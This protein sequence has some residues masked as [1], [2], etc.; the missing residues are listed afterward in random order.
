MTM[1]QQD[2]IKAFMASLA[3]HGYA[4]SNTVGKDMLDSAI[5][6]SSRYSSA[7]DVAAAMAADQLAAER[8]ALGEVLGS[9]YADKTLSEISSSIRSADA[10]TY[11]GINKSNA[12]AFHNGAIPGATVTVEDVV[13]ERKAYI[14]LEDYCGI[15]L[16][17]CYWLTN[18]NV[19]Q[20]A[21]NDGKPI[22]TTGNTDTGAITGSDADGSSTEKTAASVVPETYANTYKA[23]T[24]TAQTIITN[25][26]NW[27]VQAT[28]ND[29]TI[30]A[31]GADSI[32]AAAG[33][34]SITVNAS[35]ATVTSGAGEDVITVSQTVNDITLSDLNSDDTLT[36]S[37][38]FEIGSAHIED[39]LL[40]VT[41]KTGTRKIRLGD[42]DNAQNASV[43]INGSAS[44]TIAQWLSKA[45][46]VYS[47]LSDE[48]YAA[49]VLGN[50]NSTTEEISGEDEGRIA[51]DDYTP[52]AVEEP[53]VQQPNRI[54]AF[55]SFNTTNGD[56][57]VTVDLATV[58]ASK[59][60]DVTVNGQ[61]VGA[62]SS[63]FPNAATFT[64]NGLT[65]HLLGESSSSSPNNITAKKFDDLTDDQKTI[66]AS[67]FKW[68]ADEA[69]KLNEESYGIGFNSPTAKVKDIGL[70][71]YNDSNNILATVWNWYSTTDGTAV[72]LML[73]VNMNY[74][75]GISAND[76]N[77]IS[78]VTGAGYLDRTL[79]H[80]FTHAVMGTN[81]NFFSL[82]P[83]F[84]K[85]GSA[86]LTHGI[87][88][89]RGNVIFKLGYD[90]DSL[91]DSLN[92]DN[93][94]TGQGDAYAG[95][96]MFMRYL[97]KTAAA[98]SLPAFGKITATVNVSTDGIY[99]INGTT[100]TETAQVAASEA[101]VP[102]DA[103]KL[104]TMSGGVYTVNDTG[105]HQN[106]SGVNQVAGLT[107]NDTFTGTDNAD[108]VTT[109]QGSNIITGGG[110]DSIDVH[111]Q[112]ATINAG[113]GADTVNVLD[114]SHHSIDAGDGDNLIVFEPSLNYGNTVTSGT[115]N[116]TV[117]GGQHY[118]AVISTGAGADRVSLGYAENNFVDLGAGN[119]SILF[120]GTGNTITG[121]EG[122]DTINQYSNTDGGNVFV[123]DAE[124]FGNDSIWNFKATDKIILGAGFEYSTSVQS[125]NYTGGGTGTW[126]V[127]TV[128]KGS[129][130]VGTITVKDPTSFDAAT[131]IVTMEADSMVE[132]EGLTYNKAGYYEISD[133]QDLVDL[134]TYVNNGNDC[135][136]MIFK[137]TTD[138]DMS[139]VPNFTPIN[140][141]AVASP[142]DYFVGTFDGQDH[143]ISNL[144][145][146]KGGYEDK[147]ALFGINRGTIKNV[148][149]LNANISAYSTVA[150]I[151]VKNYGTIEN[152]FVD[153]KIHD[154]CGNNQFKAVVWINIDMEPDPTTGGLIEAGKVENCYYHVDATDE[155]ATKVYAVNAPEGFTISDINLTSGESVTIGD[156]TFY[157][158]GAQVTATVTAANDRLVIDGEP[159]FTAT[160]GNAD[161]TLDVQY[162]V[163]L[164]EGENYTNNYSNVSVLGSE[165]VDTIT[166]TGDNVTIDGAGGNDIINLN[167][168]AS[169][170]IDVS[171]GDDS[172]NVGE[173]VTS[174]S[175]S[176]FGVGDTINLLLDVEENLNVVDGKLI[177]TDGYIQF[178]IGGISAVST[179]GKAW[180]LDGNV[181]KYGDGKTA[182]AA[183]SD[184]KIIFT[185]ATVTDAKVQLGGISNLDGLSVNNNI[186]DINASAVAAGGASIV[187]NS[188]NYAFYLR[189]DWDGKTFTGT[190][191]DD[192]ISID[193]YA[194]NVSV[195]AGDGNDTIENYGGSNKTIDGGEGNDSI[196]NDGS[197]NSI[198]GGAGDDEIVNNG[199]NV[200]IDGGA[201]DDTI[202]LAG[203]MGN[204][205]NT[206]QGNDTIQISTR[207]NVND[208][209]VENF[210]A[211]DVIQFVKF[212]DKASNYVP[213]AIDSLTEVDGK[214]VATANDKSVTI[215]GLSLPTSG[216]L[217]ALDGNV[218]KYGDGL[219]AGATIDSGKIIFTNATVT[220][221]QVELGGISNL[222]GLNVD[223]TVNI[224]ASAVAAGGASIVSNADNYSFK[225][226]DDWDGKTFTGTDNADNIIFN[227]NATKVSVNAG[228]GNDHIKNYDGGWNNTIDGGDG[229][230]RITNEGNNNTINGGAGDDIIQNYSGNNNSIDGGADND[231]I[232]NYGKNTTIDGGAG[233]DE[234]I[235]KGDN[236]TID[237]GA[238]DDNIFNEASNVS[239]DGG[240]GNDTIKTSG[241][242]NNTITGGAGNDSIENSGDNNTIDGGAGNDNISNIGDN[243][244]ID[245]GAGD[246]II[247]NYSGNNN[248]I[249]GGA[250][251]DYINNYGK[252]TTID[253]GAGDDEI[254]NKGDNNTIDG[255]AGDDNIFNEASNVSIDG[256]EGNDTIKTSGGSNNTI[257]GGAG[258]DSIENSGDNNTIDGGAGNDNIS[259]IGDNVSIDGGAGDDTILLAGTTGN[260]INT[261]QGNDTIKILIDTDDPVEDFTVENF[262]VG[263][264]IQFI[265]GI[266]PV[267]ITKLEIVDGKLIATAGGTNVTIS[268]INAVSTVS[269]DGKAWSLN[270][271]VAT[272]STSLTSGAYI[273]GDKISFREST[274]VVE[275]FK[276]DGI[277]KL[278]GVS[279][280][281]IGDFDAVKINASAV[282]AG[283]A[284]I[285]Y[286]AGNYVFYLD[287]NWDGKTFT[288]SD[289]VDNIMLDG[290]ATNVSVNAGA[291]AD[292]VNVLGGS[293]NSI[294]GGADDDTIINHGK[295]NTITGGAGNDTID[296]YGS[297]TTIDG[298]AGNDSID[299]H[300]SNVSIDGGADDD[301]ILLAGTTGNTIN[302]AQGNDT[303][304]IDTEDFA[305]EFTVENFNVGDVIQFIGYEYNENWTP[306]M[307]EDQQQFEVAVAIDSLTMVDGKLVATSGGQSVIINGLDLSQENAWKLD[308]N[309]ATYFTGTSEG[310]FIDG[311][312][313]S[314]READ[315]R[316][317]QVQLGGI[318]N[319]GGLSIGDNKTVNIHASV[320]GDN[321]ASIVSNVGNYAFYLFDD[322]GGK[323]FTGSAGVDNISIDGYATNVSVN[324]GDGNDTIE[325]YGGSNKTID[326]GA[327]D[328]YIL[329]SGNNNN[330]ITGGAG[331]DTIK[332]YGSNV[333]IDGGEGNDS[334]LLVASGN[335]VNTAQGNDTIQ[336]DTENEVTDFT[337]E[338][339]GVG[340]A[341]QFVGY[342]NNPDFDPDNFDP[343]TPSKIQVDLSIDS[344]TMVDG[345]LVATAGGQS[346]IINGLDLSQE[347]A[348]KLDGN[349]ATYFTGTSE[350]AFI[351]G[352]KISF[353]EADNRVDQ[354]QL[355]GISNVGGLAIYAYNYVKIS[356]S[357]VAADGASIVSNEGNY[358][359]TLLDNW[360]GKTFTG[361]DA[362][363]FINID[364]SAKNISVD[365]GAGSDLI[366][367]DGSNV[368]IDGG[369][370]SDNIV[371]KG[372]NVSIDAGAGDDNIS[373]TASDVAINSGAGNDDISNRGNDVT[374]NAGAGNDSIENSSAKVTIDGGAG[375]NTIKLTG[376][377]GTGN[378]TDTVIKT[379]AGANTIKVGS[380]MKTFSVDG[381]G[382]NDV[383]E[384]N[385]QLTADKF[386]VV[387]GNLV[388]GDVTVG[389]M[390]TFDEGGTFTEAADGS[391]VYSVGKDSVT[392]AQTTNAE[393]VTSLV[394]I[395]N[396]SAL[397]DNTTFKLTGLVASDNTTGSIAT[398]EI[399]ATDTLTVHI[400]SSY[401]A[402]GGYYITF[403]NDTKQ[404]AFATYGDSVICVEVDEDTK[405]FPEPTGG[406]TV[407]YTAVI[408]AINAT[409]GYDISNPVTVTLADA[410]LPS[411][412][413]TITIDKATNEDQ[414]TYALALDENSSSKFAWTAT[415][416]KDDATDGQPTTYTATLTSDGGWYNET[417]SVLTHEGKTQKSFTISSTKFANSLSTD[418]IKDK[419]TFTHD[420]AIIGTGVLGKADAT[421]GGDANLRVALDSTVSQIGTNNNQLVDE[422]WTG[423]NSEG[424]TYALAHGASSEGYKI[425]S[426]T[427]KYYP[428]E[429]NAK[430]LTLTG[431]PESTTATNG[432]IEGVTV[433]DANDIYTV[434]LGDSVLNA[435][436]AYTKDYPSNNKIT[437]TAGD[438]YTDKV[439]IAV[440]STA[441]LAT[442]KDAASK[443]DA[444]LE[445]GTGDNAG[446]HVYTTDSYSAYF[447][448]GKAD[449]AAAQNTVITVN[450][451]QSGK[452]FTISG[453]KDGATTGVTFAEQTG[454]DG[455]VTGYTFTFDPT[456][457]DKKD[458]IVTPPDSITN[459]VGAISNT[460]DS[461]KTKIDANVK[462]EDGKVTFQAA[463]YEAGYLTAEEAAKASEAYTTGIHT[464]TVESGSTAVL[465]YVEQ[466]H[467][468]TFELKGLKADVASAITNVPEAQDNVI[469][470]TDG[471]TYNTSTGA[472]TLSKDALGD[473]DIVLTNSNGTTEFENS[474]TD[475]YTPYT[476]AL[477][478][479]DG[480]GKV[481]NQITVDSDN[482]TWGD[483]STKYKEAYNTALSTA[484]KTGENSSNVY[485]DKVFTAG[486]VTDTD[487][488]ATYTYTSSYNKEFFTKLPEYNAGEND[489]NKTQADALVDADVMDEEGTTTFKHYGE[490]AYFG[491]NTFTISGLKTSDVTVT[492]VREGDTA[493]ESY[494]DPV[495]VDY[496]K[497]QVVITSSALPQDTD[498]E[499]NQV[500][501]IE[502]FDSQDGDYDEK[503]KLVFDESLTKAS[504]GT[505]VM[506]D[507]FDYTVTETQDQEGK[508]TGTYTVTFA[509]NTAG[510]VNN[511]DGTYTYKAQQGGERFTIT[512]LAS[513]LTKDNITREMFTL[514]EATGEGDDATPATYTFKPTAELLD[515][516]NKS[517]TLKYN[518]VVTKLANGENGAGTLTGATVTS[519]STTNVAFDKSVIDNGTFTPAG[520]QNG[521]TEGTFVYKTAK[522]AEALAGGEAAATTSTLTFTASTGGD[523][524]VTLSGLRSDVTATTLNKNAP[525][526]YTDAEGETLTLVD[527]GNNQLYK[528]DEVEN[529][530]PKTGAQQVTPATVTLNLTDDV[531]DRTAMQSTPVYYMLGGENGDMKVTFNG[532][533]T[534]SKPP[535]GE[536][537]TLKALT[538]EGNEGKYT[539]TS[540]KTNEYYLSTSDE[541]SGISC[542]YTPKTK[543]T[544]TF[545]ISGLPENLDTTGEG[546]TAFS[547][548][549]T[550]ATTTDADNNITGATVTLAK[551]S[552]VNDIFTADKATK[553]VFAL[554]DIQID[555]KSAT[556]EYKLALPETAST[557]PGFITDDH[558]KEANGDA[559]LSTTD[560]G[561][562]YT[563]TSTK[564]SGY[565]S[566]ADD[567][568]SIDFNAS[569]GG[570][571][572]F[573][574][575]GLKY[576]SGTTD[577]LAGNKPTVQVDDDAKTIVLRDGALAKTGD[578]TIK[579]TDKGEAYDMQ[580]FDQDAYDAGLAAAKADA[581]AKLEPIGDATEVT[582][583]QKTEAESK[584]DIAYGKDY[585][586]Q[587]VTTDKTVAKANAAFEAA[588]KVFLPG[589]MPAYFTDDGNTSGTQTIAFTEATGYGDTIKITGLADNLTYDKITEGKDS[590][591]NT[592]FTVANGSTTLFVV[593]YV[594][595]SDN[596]TPE[597]TTD[598]IKEHYT[599]A[600]TNDALKAGKD[601]TYSIVVTPALATDGST[602]TLGTSNWD[603]TNLDGAKNVIAKAVGTKDGDGYTYTISLSGTS[604][605]FICTDGNL[606]STE[607]TGQ[608]TFKIGGLKSGLKATFLDKDGN[609][610]NAATYKDD[611]GNI[612]NN[613][614]V[615]LKD[616]NGKVVVSFGNY[617]DFINRSE[618]DSAK[619][620]GDY[621]TNAG[622]VRISVDALADKATAVTFTP[623]SG[624][625]FSFD[626]FVTGERVLTGANANGICESEPESAY[627]FKETANTTITDGEEVA[628]GTSNYVFE[629]K[630]LPAYFTAGTE[631]EG[632]TTYTYHKA[633]TE[634]ETFTLN[635]LKSGLTVSDVD[636]DKETSTKA[637]S[638]TLHKDAVADN[639][640]TDENETKAAVA[641]AVVLNTGAMPESDEAKTITVSDNKN[642]YALSLNEAVN[643]N[644]YNLADQGNATFEANNGKYTYTAP[645]YNAYYTDNED[646]TIDYTPARGGDTFT[647]TGL[648]EGIDSETVTKDTADDTKHVGELTFKN[649]ELSITED[650]KVT[651]KRGALPDEMTADSTIKFDGKDRTGNKVNFTLSFASLKDGGINTTEDNGAPADV[652]NNEGTVTYTSKITSHEYL[653]KASTPAEGYDETYTYNPQVGGYVI[654]I[655]GLNK[656]A[657]ATLNSNIEV[658]D[659]TYDSDGSL[660]TPGKVTLYAGI[661]QPLSDVSSGV[662]ISISSNDDNRVNDG[663][664]L[665]ALDTG[666]STKAV[667][668]QDKY[669]SF[670]YTSGTYTFTASGNTAGYTVKNTLD[671]DGKTV[672][673]NII[674]KAASGETTF[675]ITG[676]KTDLV[677]TG[678]STKSVEEQLKT[679]GITIGKASDGKVT[680]TITSADVFANKDG[681]KIT[682]TDGK[683]DDGVTYK[684]ALGS[685]IPT[686]K[687]AAVNAGKIQVTKVQNGTA[688]VTTTHTEAYYEVDTQNSNSYIYHAPTASKTF[689]IT[690]LASGKTVDELNEAL[691]FTETKND[692]TGKTD[693]IIT[694]SDTSIFGTGT[695]KPS[696]LSGYNITF[697]K[698]Q[699]VSGDTPIAE[700]ATEETGTWAVKDGTATYK[701]GDKAAF[702]SVASAD[703]FTEV[704]YVD[705]VAGA[706]HFALSGLAANF[707][708]VN[709]DSIKY[710]K[711]TKTVTIK[712]TTDN[713]AKAEDGLTITANNDAYKVVLDSAIK[714]TGTSSADT[715][716]V[717][718]AGAHFDAKDGNDV[719]DVTEAAFVDGGAGNDSIDIADGKAVTLNFSAGFDT[720]SYDSELVIAGLDKGRSYSFKNLQSGAVTDGVIKAGSGDLLLTDG[721]NKLLIVGGAG[722]E[723]TF[724]DSEGK[725]SSETFNKAF[726]EMLTFSGKT[727][728]TVN[729][730]DVGDPKIPF[731]GSSLGANEF[732]VNDAADDIV[733]IDASPYDTGTDGLTIEGNA[734][735]NVITGTKYNDSIN[736]GAAT[737]PSLSTDTVTGGAG[738]D[739]IVYNDGKLTIKD[740]N[741]NGTDEVDVIKFG[742]GNFSITKETISGNN[743]VFGI[744]TDTATRS[745]TLTDALGK[746]S[747]QVKVVDADGAQ[748]N[749]NIYF[750]DGSIVNEDETGVTLTSAYKFPTGG[751]LAPST[752][753][754]IQADNTVA[755]ILNASAAAAVEITSSAANNTLIGS[756]GNDTLTGAANKADLF[757]YT[758]QGADTVTNFEKG[759]KVSLAAVDGTSL[760]AGKL[761]DVSLI[762]AAPDDTSTTDK[763]ERAIK[764]TFGSGKT[765]ELQ[766]AE[767][768]NAININGKNYFVGENMFLDNVAP[769]AT[770]VTLTA[771]REDNFD[772]TEKNGSDNIYNTNLKTIDAS[773][774]TVTGFN[775]TGNDAVNSIVAGTG[776]QLVI[777]A[778]KGNDTV[779]VSK[780]GGKNT[781]K[782]GG[783]VD[784]IIGG[785]ESGNVYVFTASGTSDKLTI[786]NFTAGDAI[787]V[788][789]GD[790]VTLGE[791]KASVDAE[792]NV[793]FTAYD[794]SATPKAVGT[795]TVEGV[796][797]VTGGTKISLKSAADD[798]NYTYSTAGILGG[799]SITLGSA[800]SGAVTA[801]TA[802]VSNAINVDATNAP[803]VTHITAS[804]E[805]GTLVGNAGNNSLIGSTAADVLIGAAG[806]D[807]LYGGVNDKVNNAVPADTLTGGA[808]NDVFYF[809]GGNV[810]ITD[811]SASGNLGADKIFVDGKR[812]LANYEIDKATKNLTL[813]YVD[814][815]GESGK[816]VIEKGTD[817]Q[818]TFTDGKNTNVAF[819]STAGIFDKAVPS[820]A[821]AITLDAATNSFDAQANFTAY[822]KLVTIDS[823]AVTAA[824]G[825]FIAVTGNSLANCLNNSANSNAATL[826]GGD[827]NDTLLAGAG[828]DSLAGGV[829]ND[830][831]VLG[832]GKDT[833]LV[834]DN[835]T[836]AAAGNDT[837]RNFTSDD[838]LALADNVDFLDATVKG[839]DLTL[840][841]KG[842]DEENAKTYGKSV[843]TVVLAGAVTG[844]EIEVGIGLRLYKFGSDGRITVDKEVR[845]TSAFTGKTFE[846]NDSVEKIDASTNTRG[847]SITGGKST[848]TIVGSAG[849]DLLTMTVANG[850]VDGSAG[851]DTIN[852]SGTGSSVTGGKGND[853]FVYSGGVL[854]V[855]DFGNGTDKISLAGT[856]DASL[857]MKD[858]E[859]VTFTAVDGDEKAADIELGFGTGNTLTLRVADSVKTTA[860][861]FMDGDT[862]TGAGKGKAYKFVDGGIAV[863]NSLTLISGTDTV[864]MSLD[865]LKSYRSVT[866]NYADA[867]IL[868][869]T[870]KSNNIALNET[871]LAVGG[872]KSD[873][874]IANAAVTLEGGKGNDT[875]VIR[876]T[877]AT[878]AD[879]SSVSGN[880]DKI[881]IDAALG[882]F[883]S[884]DVDGDDITLTYTVKGGDDNT[885][886]QNTL[887]V[888]GG[889]KG[890]GKLDLVEGKTR[891]VRKFTTL[892]SFNKN[893]TAVTLSAGLN[894]DF[895]A[896]TYNADNK[897]RIVSINSA[898]VGGGEITAASLASFI[899]NDGNTNA[900]TLTGGRAKDLIVAGDGGDIIDG[901]K[902]ND[903]LVGG[904]GADSFVI[905]L[906]DEGK[907][908]ITAGNDVIVG[909]GTGDNLSLQSGIFLAD[910]SFKTNRTVNEF[911]STTGKLVASKTKGTDFVLTFR[912]ED[913]GKVADVVTLQGVEWNEVNGIKSSVNGADVTIGDET[914]TFFADGKIAKG[915]AITLTSDYKNKSFVD[916]L[917][918]DGAAKY[919]SIYAAASTRG[920]SI[921][922]G[923]ESK[924][925]ITVTGGSGSDL[926]KL[927]AKATASDVQFTGGKGNDTFTYGGGTVTV[928]DYS[929]AGFLGS[930][931]ITLASGFAM[932]TDAESDNAPKTLTAVEVDNETVNLTFGEESDILSLTLADSTKPTVTIADNQS[933]KSGGAGTNGTAYTF[934]DGLFGVG[935]S[936]TVLAENGTFGKA[937][938]ID[939]KVYRSVT[940]GAVTLDGSQAKSALKL[941]LTDDGKASGG[942]GADSLVGT[943]GGTLI[944]GAGGDKFIIAGAGDYVITDY[945][946]GDKISV[947][948]DVGKLTDVES[949]S[950]GYKLTFDTGSDT[951]TLT[952]ENVT[953]GTPI[954]LTTTELVKNKP[955]ATTTTVY[956]DD[957][958]LYNKA[959]I[960]GGAYVGNNN[961]TKVT[962]TARDADNDFGGRSADATVWTP[963]YKSMAS[964]TACTANGNTVYGNN[965]ANTITLDDGG[966][967]MGGLGADTYIIKGGDVVIEDFGI[968]ATNIYSDGK[969]STLASK[970]TGKGYDYED[971]T[972]YAPGSD[973][974]KINGKIISVAI[975]GIDSLAAAKKDTN[976]GGAFS[977]TLTVDYDY[978]DTENRGQ[979]TGT[980]VLNNVLRNRVLTDGEAVNKAASSTDLGKLKI[981]DIEKSG[982][983]YTRLTWAKGLAPLLDAEYDATG[984]GRAALDEIM[985]ET[986]AGYSGSDNTVNDPFDNNGTQA[987]AGG[988]SSSNK[989][990]H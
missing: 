94:G 266:N 291:G 866:V 113:A 314:F 177:A 740:F 557:T 14:F 179:D 655:S 602:R 103:I 305:E 974:L 34:D 237:G 643:T 964:I 856:G 140:N 45:G 694:V 613:T 442:T 704:K 100:T 534:V 208:F 629:D 63:E 121:G 555:G 564:Y 515:K 632:T 304:K 839:S 395:K 548:Y 673:N 149:L 406:T 635:N 697:A 474:G 767:S 462:V 556:G 158:Q 879:Y 252:N 919:D 644:K 153:G 48:S 816:L 793:V 871:G 892:G 851:S 693:V 588:Y 705:T 783:G 758:G 23:T 169:V 665:L 938:G 330:T 383:I 542:T 877:D 805:A 599:V 46:I 408:D 163:Q 569:R 709:D 387:E 401:S 884:G 954:A 170:L 746:D 317:D 939:G 339:F 372:S 973:T 49:Q 333:S 313:I 57:S 637:V 640:E 912:Y 26:R 957:H 690:G 678:D 81:I 40:V 942:K 718:A 41:D 615:G 608:E 28:D 423:S 396:G 97:A 768:V 150:G 650:G 675:T 772:A 725:K 761:G 670:K 245:G 563:Y 780:S 173:G 898:A 282:A 284:S 762:S 74:Y 723:V 458:V 691:S 869:Q 467:G 584:A 65:I 31:N 754:K 607:A 288:G 194:T 521:D 814:T 188:G 822:P 331:D 186:V 265:D 328:D 338:G 381:F 491:K 948:A 311:D 62:V 61:V 303:I 664:Y 594:K 446:K 797:T 241:G 178:T 485:V 496:Q 439:A 786:K 246:D 617:D 101:D 430:V 748:V 138:I 105:V 200:L 87:D 86:E 490:G 307:P 272:Y 855:T 905:G 295:N 296:N 386:K 969:I 526:T 639:P 6:A 55:G 662:T 420:T 917:G 893:E 733:T 944:G 882:S 539:Y 983:T 38:E 279:V 600:P 384:L 410:L 468:E 448:A 791:T 648:K 867:T 671:D 298:G 222:D 577:L 970:V 958:A 784:V 792:G 688:T 374:I 131:N 364:G 33:N 30:T 445:A 802:A 453:L 559:T 907:S 1:T 659:P 287:G 221:A 477:D 825:A 204:T 872:D 389:G 498:R 144:T 963:Q 486:T 72:Q 626:G 831:F 182:G 27:V 2:V 230:D 747:V 300:A 441:D 13:K 25:D 35:G 460:Y 808:G 623:D 356:A 277:S 202:F 508:G 42:F 110:D 676:L 876:A 595:A 238:G 373:N 484:V 43:N 721:S 756:A 350:G 17:N 903:T 4:S 352:D 837:I 145:I 29:D 833:V 730:S 568:L 578:I 209:T 203:K 195:N 894:D 533:E 685:S 398:K 135:R 755:G 631:S 934:R 267:N 857:S 419:V 482:I 345:K 261:E 741:S 500:V 847:V 625:T 540:A 96:Y 136:D 946:K 263:D 519:D 463:G 416:A 503:F 820:L 205:I 479:N 887:F 337:V 165:A 824:A 573:T 988:G 702:Y 571:E 776:A 114:G 961:A 218:A 340:D 431:L 3:N 895:N 225:L 753:T 240:E 596:G 789:A 536:A 142:T 826:S 656:T 461:G 978:W 712:T 727:G 76:M 661:L 953:S 502:G 219:T 848:S 518:G 880:K 940:G 658:T 160:I 695:I 348:W 850:S 683:A 945:T 11:A 369:D 921:T 524:L 382:R 986:P 351:D 280:G 952:L 904:D 268:G 233:D 449:G 471:V 689:T 728:V 102:T 409:S 354:V 152:C 543:G 234:I 759:D 796:G 243:V 703:S 829:G 116:D 842:T 167:G 874:L 782:A 654:T 196:R 312:K 128:T 843:G 134:A 651:L 736:P 565:L 129:D 873:T 580:L 109:A 788:V 310:A 537:A 544:L 669:G 955:K 959:S 413:G 677:C 815:D 278:D 54:K 220:N 232:N 189:D 290:E 967:V 813:N 627:V 717:N 636:I 421:V 801:G 375:S 476:L 309:V 764:F 358:N 495:T 968:G 586:N 576:T 69:I 752:V 264:A 706:E 292:T 227:G 821:T 459:I 281:K 868:G 257:T 590:D 329:N 367:N 836:L 166:N 83:Q 37:G 553:G 538:G 716:T 745:I 838:K 674:Y 916:T 511:E 125:V 469:T 223:N 585:A 67:L 180:A 92:V 971:P 642:S 770:G 698:A 294:D 860:F 609:P 507:E 347:N 614:F 972:T 720:V 864:D 215:G 549:F 619:T 751:F 509:G 84:I 378:V 473:K 154:T 385:G 803:K 480:E 504:G 192:N 889:A 36:I 641:G 315:N 680:V 297:N 391:I 361:S 52:P 85:E 734:Q 901:G 12:N 16:E 119:D 981:Y 139:S 620:I 32:N 844:Q 359:F 604:A 326:G 472:I 713:V 454:D 51:L 634:F 700:Y 582:D 78:N 743:I 183:V 522:T 781:V 561:K 936:A 567:G 452:T 377:N 667:T 666:N 854:T 989:N 302:T 199:S 112:Y 137:V 773:A 853:V 168:G 787:S 174:F 379:A 184:G 699:S 481:T 795:V 56:G 883:A 531:I 888:T 528:S 433:D 343:N 859:S 489:E 966:T 247:Q 457:L 127:V 927:D 724:V 987:Y 517:I 235:N 353:R 735:N 193:G 130:T 933:K 618:S 766:G 652:K 935:K 566:V 411:S 332:N 572:L 93:N 975:D 562:T 777:D 197:N 535:A 285:V 930:D 845:I 89:E 320:V 749:N 286:N 321:G 464:P 322:W 5:R 663:D 686:D 645:K 804:N 601:Q 107:V 682:L 478:S 255:G 865:S 598:D 143:V 274:I 593:T 363:N 432:A 483:D 20:Y 870:N 95:G 918:T 141:L 426:T 849:N 198:T 589:Y 162:H 10:K 422:G 429:T 979:S 711:D 647:I 523:T 360:N 335:T 75:S 213:V 275:Q 376:N 817:T 201:D 909:F 794:N 554:S 505:Y 21:D 299:N 438:N 984:N 512:G 633:E 402:V 605:G 687:T 99:Y 858:L 513:G 681:D 443:N 212:D 229:N 418:S 115:G 306:D 902:G 9:E 701:S 890:G 185:D 88:D 393:N 799:N 760:K 493:L 159:S 763:D 355:G 616:T 812:S 211:G 260:T 175:V 926:L 621:S 336:I 897:A 985:G 424:F 456:I 161:T 499:A 19:K 53:V 394:Y 830:L 769:Q 707:T 624:K 943:K 592:T 171:K 327:G 214:L 392:V 514:T 581:V 334:I 126:H 532:T 757:V 527:I 960:V 64:R 722:R 861:N 653:A 976:E 270:N 610:T 765:L 679:K 834:G 444:K 910:A 293:N 117:K 132:I 790:N 407:S 344:L 399:N 397:A 977:V 437:V 325:N 7:S 181:A 915:D 785:E 44:T 259:N 451:E 256:G 982:G 638:I 668:A 362:T 941:T 242:S 111:G 50:N 8:Q 737:T 520:W 546:I 742:S 684:L 775:I 878:I 455:K 156:K 657:T 276:L 714:L 603:G 875:F 551:D 924:N 318:S 47:S 806:N 15:Q 253:G 649:G 466:R 380:D 732:A 913:T 342:R 164:A 224:H 90:A 68:W 324:A 840:S 925:S 428:D 906:G 506:S 900:L 24:S 591:D 254:I 190:D 70:Y 744:G 470:L 778:G 947:G 516:N 891:I 106:I 122:D 862:V 323:T 450:P 809:N 425:E 529:G 258:N 488:S 465:T 929:K 357:A 738:N 646:N 774:V 66:V 980:I 187:S 191:D 226:F 123:F 22:D 881:S 525:L 708:E 308:G 886:T 530:K 547:D 289:T 316:V 147:A 146:T 560:S 341:I 414:N 920:L 98:N 475:T 283:G 176:G 956:L 574:I 440:D 962:L 835:G 244:S 91:A 271:N 18:G 899:N 863:G 696:T 417:S 151:A 550:V 73:N 239:I 71:F 447:V 950:D 405:Q 148:K 371:N 931:K 120:G 58:D 436:A 390:G 346:V 922:G 217:W 731:Y 427:L 349:V 739:T 823:G 819:Y 579:A 896:A 846:G 719:I 715:V 133:A 726:G 630:H 885:V 77:G 937:A 771:G 827:G 492:E 828:G 365:G 59:A 248:S 710:D 800:V 435:A 415:W 807:T 611:K 487:K 210:T 583:E 541:N 82:L 818:L 434:K 832:D 951:T 157:K 273:D 412:G 269:T 660:N 319:V 206:A 207:N 923:D 612:V 908:S 250:D 124:N 400:D 172:I 932:G 388:A 301:T 692:D 798:S 928:T 370:G 494:T 251:N 570:E 914:Y 404:Y 672:T 262:G 216:N 545:T 606:S 558:N 501:K 228:A 628:D 597:D 949:V 750:K 108:T 990:N 729:G 552:A 852:A 911:D 60:G 231:Y 366:I 587:I 497:K 249:D 368:S 104:G 80:E 575:S 510:Y 155:N 236:N 841:F 811:Y 810:V 965:K 118:D 779:D 39:T 622:K 79:A 403:D